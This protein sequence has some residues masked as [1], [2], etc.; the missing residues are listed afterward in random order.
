[1]KRICRPPRESS[2]MRVVG[3][4]ADDC[5]WRAVCLK[6]L[7][8]TQRPIPFSAL[9]SCVILSPFARQCSFGGA[10]NKVMEDCRNVVQIFRRSKLAREQGI[11]IRRM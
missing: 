7:N 9:P 2:L 5:L 11:R 4:L 6:D 1:M 3:R 10:A 8:L